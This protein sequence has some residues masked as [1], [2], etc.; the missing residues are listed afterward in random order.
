MLIFF[1][2][3]CKPIL[4]NIQGPYPCPPPP[5]LSSK[6]WYVF[7]DGNLLPQQGTAE[8]GT[9]PAFLAV[10]PLQSDRLGREAEP[11]IDN[12]TTW[13]GRMFQLVVFSRKQFL[14]WAL[15]I[16][17]LRDF[18]KCETYCLLEN[19]REYGN[20]CLGFNDLSRMFQ[21][22]ILFFSAFVWLRCLCAQ[23]ITASC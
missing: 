14:N 15:W 20:I 21:L 7:K 5:V 4:H 8:N 2:F 9:P 16:S 3:F 13:Q 6:K 17:N 19:Q 23:I 22:D 12:N 11:G 18:L 10:C 1:F